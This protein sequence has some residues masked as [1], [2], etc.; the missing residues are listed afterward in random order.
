MKWAKWGKKDE[1]SSITQATKTFI[2]SAGDQGVEGLPFILEE[3]SSVS[4]GSAANS[5]EVFD[6]IKKY[7]TTERDWA[8]ERQLKCIELLK[9]LCNEH[10]FILLLTSD[11]KFLKSM[12]QQISQKRPEIGRATKSLIDSLARKPDAPIELTE[13]HNRHVD[14]FAAPHHDGATNPT[15]VLSNEQVIAGDI[16]EAEG[17]IDLLTT[18]LAD[19]S[20]DP[21]VREVHI[22]MIGVKERLEVDLEKS[23]H[24]KQTAHIISTIEHIERLLCLYKEVYNRETPHGEGGNSHQSFEDRGESALSRGRP[25]DKGKGR[26]VD[27]QSSNPSNYDHQEGSSK[28]R[29]REIESFRKSTDGVRDHRLK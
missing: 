1:I 12:E 23:I 9:Y 3:C 25:R 22:K 29:E 13:M 24:E 8:K 26:A 19:T 4:S 16:Q 15:I 17:V 14:D 10:S 2:K 18:L 20:S 21:L 28:S 11:K 27:G 7:Y 5:V 6:L